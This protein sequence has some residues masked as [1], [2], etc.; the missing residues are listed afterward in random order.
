MMKMDPLNV[1][2][3]SVTTTLSEDL[4]HLYFLH[5]NKILTV[6]ALEYRLRKGDG[7]AIPVTGR[8]G[9]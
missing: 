5:Y 2:S 8:E 7:K 6:S 4:L 1:V 9:P 3:H